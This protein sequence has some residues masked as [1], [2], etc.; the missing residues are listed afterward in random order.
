MRLRFALP[1][2]TALMQAKGGSVASAHVAGPHGLVGW[3]F[4]DPVEGQGPLPMRLVITRN[5][6]VLRRISGDPFL[7]KWIFE[8]DGS[9]VAIESGPLHGSMNC[10]LIDLRSGTETQRYDCF[11]QAPPDAP[12]WVKD[13]EGSASLNL[14]P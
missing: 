9:Q 1:L 6:K 4:S 14:L 12:Q 5:G 3:T 13:L 10:M 8:A 11:R 7:W 2:F